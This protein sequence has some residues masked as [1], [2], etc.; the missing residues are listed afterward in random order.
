MK[1]LR[2]SLLEDRIAE[3]K[4]EV[5]LQNKRRDNAEKELKKANNKLDELHREWSNYHMELKFIEYK[6]EESFK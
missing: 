1:T 3:I 5:K 4:A 6:R 2:E